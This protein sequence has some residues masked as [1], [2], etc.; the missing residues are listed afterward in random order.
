M[1]NKNTN[2]NDGIYQTE[3]GAATTGGIASLEK[4][5]SNTFEKT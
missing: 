4:T 3:L 1:I 2:K 5:V